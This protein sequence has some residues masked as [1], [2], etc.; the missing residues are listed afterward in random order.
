MLHMTKAKKQPSWE[1]AGVPAVTDAGDD[2]SS[3][4]ILIGDAC[5]LGDL[6]VS[7]QPRAHR[8][9]PLNGWRRGTGEGLWCVMG[10]PRTYHLLLKRSEGSGTIL[11]RIGHWGGDLLVLHFLLSWSL[12][13]FDSSL[14]WIKYEWR[15]LF[16]RKTHQFLDKWQIYC[17]VF[18]QTSFFTYKCPTLPPPLTYKI[19]G[20]NTYNFGHN[21]IVTYQIIDVTN[22]NHL[23]PGMWVW[24][25]D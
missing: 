18:R 19:E 10:A 12:L 15:V 17:Q 14:V 13:I 2:R 16:I 21:L 6:L 8:S 1:S 9:C 11:S 24:Q 3:S 4:R 5:Q 23:F 20:D 22:R 7:N 25:S